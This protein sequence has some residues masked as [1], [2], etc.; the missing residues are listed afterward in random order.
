[1][2]KIYAKL[3]MAIIARWILIKAIRGIAWLRGIKL[4]VDSDGSPI[5]YRR[6]QE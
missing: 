6:D 5:G 1:M 4:V 2:I 3:Y